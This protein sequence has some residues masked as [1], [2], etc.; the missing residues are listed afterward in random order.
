M[1]NGRP[2]FLI[3][4]TDQQAG[5]TQRAGSGVHMPNLERLKA[6]GVSFEQ[7]FCPAPHC[8]PSRASFFTGLYPSEHG[9]W[10]NVDLAGA[11]S[12]GLYD[13]VRLFSQ[14]LREAGYE[15]YFSGKW[16]VSA[17]A[18]PEAYGFDSRL[19]LPGLKRP[20]GRW[21]RRPDMRD[22]RWLE[23]G[24]YPDEAVKQGPGSIPRPGYPSYRLYGERE[25]PYGDEEV[26]SCACK[27]LKDMDKSR[28]FCLYVGPKGPHDPYVV[29]GQYVELYP[30]GSV[31]LPDSF[32]DEM[33]DKPGLYR[34]TRERFGILDRK[35]QE[36]AL[37]HYYGFCSYE[38]ALF[39]RILDTLK[40]E[41]LLDDTIVFYL[42]DHGDYAG[43]HGLWTK[44]LPCFEEAYHICSV[45]GFGGIQ[46]ACGEENRVV[47]EPVCL[48]DYAPTILE[49]AGIQRENRLSG[50]SLVPFLEGTRP[51]TWRR[52]VY[53]QTNGNE[54]YGIQRSVF[55]EDFHFVFNAFDYDELYDRKK[56]PDCMRNL[57]R[58][59]GYQPVVR[60]MYEKLWRFAYD[61]RDGLGDPYITTALA[62][63]GPGV[64]RDHT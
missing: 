52:E 58:E 3:F 56:D 34:R 62:Q 55:T 21:E 46:A 4:M 59:G 40:E 30:E 57:I 26:V 54:C 2:N 5:L 12:H 39:G 13:G 11:L 14:E 25:D 29:P 61:H 24:N 33:E 18:G 6:N 10:N 51:K 37:R 31:R 63:F 23:T 20:F 16:H 8:C 53:T 7:A 38:D 43:A 44:G 49:L 22:Y 36:E 15:M 19:Y 35:E 17:E 27:W 41:K 42:S 48:V 47:E 9:V 28:P 60:G 64:M 1:R 32:G 50:M 45:A